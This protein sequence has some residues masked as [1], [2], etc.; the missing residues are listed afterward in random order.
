MSFRSTHRREQPNIELTPM[1]DVMFNLVLFFV[2][3]TNFRYDQE[4]TPSIEVDLPQ[5][6]AR[7]VL[8]DSTD[9]N[10]WVTAEGSVFLGEDPVDLEGLRRAF[11]DR[12]AHNPQ[13]AVVIKAD[14]GVTHGRVVRI[15]DLARL[16]GL[17]NLAIATEASQGGDDR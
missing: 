17:V 8:Q 1:I 7:A 9:L 10:V 6:S 13:S 12:A 3:T 5:A 15:M 11:A 4:Q 14:E 2:V 16:H